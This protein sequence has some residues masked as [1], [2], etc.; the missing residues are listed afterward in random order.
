DEPIAHPH[1]HW[2]SGD[3]KYM[4]TPNVNLYNASIVDIKK[5]TFRHDVTGEFPI[6]TGMDP[7][8]TKAYMA[9]FLGATISCVTLAPKGKACVGDDGQKEHGKLIDLWDNYNMIDGPTGGWGGLPI[10]IAVSPDDSGGLVANTLSSQLG[11]FDPKT[12]KMVGYLPCDAGCHGI[13]YGAKKGGGYYAYV[14]SK[15][16]NVLSVIDIDPNGDGNPADAAV[17][18]RILTNADSAT[19]VDDQVIDYAG[20]GGQGVLPIPLAYEGWVEHAPKNAINNQLTCKQRNP[21]K[22]A[23]VC[24]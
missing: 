1:A 21:V 10:Q 23:K 9:D 19:Q 4:A 22:F 17:V 12:D 7:A 15:F 2:M 8:S 24:K 16:A 18:G 3:A 13:N 20:M 11:V 6:A 5:G 14:S